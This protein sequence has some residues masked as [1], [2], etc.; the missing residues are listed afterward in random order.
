MDQD[1]CSALATAL[2]VDVKILR[3]SPRRNELPLSQFLDLIILK[4][5]AFKPRYARLGLLIQKYADTYNQRLVQRFPNDSESQYL[6]VLSEDVSSLISNA[7]RGEAVAFLKALIHCVWENNHDIGV[8]SQPPITRGSLSLVEWIKAAI[9][10]ISSESNSKKNVETT[11][12]VSDKTSDIT[13]VNQLLFLRYKHPHTQERETIEATINSLRNSGVFV[14]DALIDANNAD[15]VNDDIRKY[16]SK[17][18]PILMIVCLS[19]GMIKKI[20]PLPSAKS[21]LQEL[22]AQPSNVVLVI[23]EDADLHLDRLGISQFQGMSLHMEYGSTKLFDNISRASYKKRLGLSEFEK[24]SQ[25]SRRIFSGIRKLETSFNPPSYD[26]RGNVLTIFVFDV[27]GMSILNRFH[28]EDVGNLVVE[29]IRETLLKWA[30]ISGGTAD[31]FGD[32]S[33]FLSI[34]YENS[35][36]FV[37]R[38]LEDIKN[39]GWQSI[40]TGLWVTISV[41]TAVR[42]QYSEELGMDVVMRALLGLREAKRKGGNCIEPGP[43]LLPHSSRGNRRKYYELY[44]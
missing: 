22:L 33:F 43:L 7:K 29:V 2:L 6:K 36:Q 17:E 27:D 12:Y 38:F 20:A 37:F 1:D 14:R 3:N 9:Q 32:D 25:L 19:P 26:E 13:A 15:A 10:Q 34:P 31:Q 40:S 21:L 4:H 8:F 30:E 42:E 18:T 44:S 5:A 16:L 23:T 28:G 24:H 41:G 39:F 11:N 35:D